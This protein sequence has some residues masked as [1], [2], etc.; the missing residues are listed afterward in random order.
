MCCIESRFNH[1]GYKVYSQMES[2]LVNAAK[3]KDYSE[4]FEA[5]CSFLGNDIDNRL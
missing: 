3:N 1:P 5:V 4:Q 2:L